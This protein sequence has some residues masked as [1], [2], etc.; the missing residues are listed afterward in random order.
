MISSELT[1]FRHFSSKG[2]LCRF[3]QSVDHEGPNTLFITTTSGFWCRTCKLKV[4]DNL[5]P[6]FKFYQRERCTV[7][8]LYLKCIYVGIDVEIKSIHLSVFKFVWVCQAQEINVQDFSVNGTLI[9]INKLIFYCTVVL[10][11]IFSHDITLIS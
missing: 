8:Y 4:L 3:L 6:T 7:L 10:F 5:L 2:L 9:T 1:V 11:Y